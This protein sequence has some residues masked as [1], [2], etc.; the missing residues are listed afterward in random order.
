M[1]QHHAWDLVHLPS[2][3]KAIGCKW[4]F[5]IKRDA[6]GA[7]HRYI[8]A[9]SNKRVCPNS[10]QNYEETFTPIAKMAMIRSILSLAASKG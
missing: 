5:T 9:A 8:T 6:D 2:D 4:V 3:R 1:Q 7:V 10:R